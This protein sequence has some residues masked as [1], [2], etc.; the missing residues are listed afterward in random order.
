MAGVEKRL[1]RLKKLQDAG[2]RF[3]FDTIGQVQTH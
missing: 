2:Y 3:G 1:M